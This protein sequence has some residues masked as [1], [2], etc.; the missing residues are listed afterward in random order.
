MNDYIRFIGQPSTWFGVAAF[1][2]QVY[3]GTLT[4]EAAG[5]VPAAFGL[6][7]VDA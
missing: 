1:A 2:V 5:I 3:T 4:P 6:I 7:G